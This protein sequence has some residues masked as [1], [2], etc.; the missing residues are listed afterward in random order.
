MKVIL[1][2]VLDKM[3]NVGYYF[4]KIFL[5]IFNYIFS[6]IILIDGTHVPVQVVLLYVNKTT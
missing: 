5:A 2:Q 3:A 6:V 4:K 1:P